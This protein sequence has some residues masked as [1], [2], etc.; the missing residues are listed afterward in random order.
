MEL[1]ALRTL[2]PVVVMI[3]VLAACGRLG[4]DTGMVRA[5]RSGRESVSLQQNDSINV[6][7]VAFRCRDSGSCLILHF[8]ANEVVA[9]DIAAVRDF[10][11]SLADVV[12]CN[13]DCLFCLNCAISLIIGSNAR[14]STI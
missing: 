4:T 3:V 13:W 7:S 5:C 2:E 10:E 1:N 9:I 6:A 12:G 8:Q 11:N 14:N